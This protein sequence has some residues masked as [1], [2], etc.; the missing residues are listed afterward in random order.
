MTT[1]SHVCILFLHQRVLQ[2][3]KELSECTL[4]REEVVLRLL[5]VKNHFIYLSRRRD[6]EKT[7]ICRRSHQ[8]NYSK[9]GLMTESKKA[10][11]YKLQKMLVYIFVHLPKCK[12]FLSKI[13]GL[14]IRWFHESR[15]CFTKFAA[16][17]DL[18]IVPSL[19]I[20]LL[21]Y[22]GNN[23]NHAWKLKI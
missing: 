16:C 9:S 8:D 10:I 7:L 20:L 19:M 23:S 21:H 2:M 13:N 11:R 3:L 4:S 5:A 14:L 1:S 22:H 12:F 15:I 17:F 6:S 18:V